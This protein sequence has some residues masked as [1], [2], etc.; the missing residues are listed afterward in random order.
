M[1]HL[2]I[3]IPPRGTTK[4]QNLYFL[5]FHISTFPNFFPP[6]SPAADRHWTD[7]GPPAT[8]SLT[9][10]SVVA[11]WLL[12]A[13]FTVPDCEP[14]S[15]CSLTHSLTHSLVRPRWSY[16]LS[17][18]HDM[19]TLNATINHVFLIVEAFDELTQSQTHH[20]LLHSTPPLILI[21]NHS[22][23]RVTHLLP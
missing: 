12:L 6:R 22:L 21:H 5:F 16:P 23:R 15:E 8:H 9:G 1:I 4:P 13:L 3:R 11:D 20:S 2:F 7:A 14:S 18:F 19:F 17:V 10:G